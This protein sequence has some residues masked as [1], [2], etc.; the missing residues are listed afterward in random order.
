M[1]KKT[2]SASRRAHKAVGDSKFLFFFALSL[3]FPDC[4]TLPPRISLSILSALSAE[5]AWADDVI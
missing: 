2:G 1:L 3:H 4:V 5:R